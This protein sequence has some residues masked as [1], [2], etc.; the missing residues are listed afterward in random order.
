MS[1]KNLVETVIAAPR[2]LRERAALN[3]ALA[4]FAPERLQNAW[5]TSVQ[6]AASNGDFFSALAL[7]RL[8]LQGALLEQS[9]R[10][11]AMLYAKDRRQIAF[12]SKSSGLVPVGTKVPESGKELERFAIAVATALP[13]ALEMPDPSYSVPLFGELTTEAFVALAKGME[14]ARFARGDVLVQQG[15]H[16]PALYLLTHGEVEVVQTRE[17]EGEKETIHLAKVPAPTLIG[18]MSLMTN[19]APR[20]SVL[21]LTDSIAWK[22]NSELIQSLTGQHPELPQHFRRLLQRRL[23]NNMLRTSTLFK[24]LEDRET[25]LR[26]FALRVVELDEE[27]FG[28]GI[29]PPGLFVI[30]HGQA[31]V[32]KQTDDGRRVWV[33]DLYEGDTF[34]EFSLLTGELTT[35]SIW[36]P[37]GGMLLHLLPKTY[38]TIKQQNPNIEEEL[39]KLMGERKQRLEQVI[40]PITSAVEIQQ[41]DWL[42]GTLEADDLF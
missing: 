22:I 8:H 20:A 6:W 26:S 36:M 3:M 17:H 9:L 32:Y 2:S 7:A 1:L 5:A 29:R 16:V 28:Q 27:V 42:F 33:A 35:A 23:L 31:V 40:A 12:A 4:A 21:A 37:N 10:K 18:E 41:A 19:L 38:H 13:S 15:H 30:L 25:I 34:G 24:H 11:L 39:K 14:P